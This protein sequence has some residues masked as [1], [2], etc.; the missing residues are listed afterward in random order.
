MSNR[1]LYSRV[2]SDWGLAPLFAGIVALYLISLYD[3]AVFHTLVEAMSVTVATAVFI[4]VFHTRRLLDNHYLLFVSIGFLAFVALGI[5]H[6]LGYK[7]IQLFSGFDNDL[8]T[9]AFV[10]QRFVLASSFLFAPAFLRRKLNVPM[11]FLGFGVVTVFVLASLLVWRN[12]PPM[13]VDPVG[14]TPLKKGLEFVL[15]AM[16][17][18]AAMGLARNRQ[19]FEPNVLNLAL[20]SLGCF[21]ASEVSFTL[22]ATPFGLSNLLGHLFQVAAFWFIYRAVLVTALVNPFGLLFRQLA[23]R[24]SSLSEA[25][26]QLN[27]IAAVSDAA[28]SSLEGDTLGPVVLERLVEVMAADAG[29]LFLYDGEV[30]RADSYVGIEEPGFA[31]R[32]GEG[33]AGSIA[34]HRQPDFIE[35]IQADARIKS[36]FLR[37]QGVRSI[38]G[39]PLVSGDRL[40]GVLHVDWRTVHPFSEAEMRLLVI[41]GDRVA[42]AL[43]NSQMYENEHHIAQVLQ[44]SLLALPEMVEGVCFASAY[45]SASQA[46]RVG[47]DFYDV[48]E[49]DSNRVGVLVGDVSGKGLDAAVQTSLLRNTVRA[50]AMERSKTPGEVMSM[51][52]TV[53][54]K[55]T[56]SGTFATVF[57]AII[58]GRDGR[59]A[60]CNAGHTAAVVL[61]PDGAVGQFPAQSP[62]VGAFPDSVFSSA[63]TLLERGDTLFVYTDGVIESR[64]G[65]AL[66]GE[67]RLF[68]FLSTQGGRTPAEIIEAVMSDVVAFT[69]SALSDD[70]ALLAVQTC[71][72]T[73]GTSWQQEITAGDLPLL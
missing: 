2:K 68:E 70:I 30:L 15:S 41:I 3:Y 33:F 69:E 17:I 55:A 48:F 27:A 11:A 31:L 53:F 5:P 25:N 23:E 16:F 18:G 22:Y 38:L 60:Y 57:F 65:S 14:L 43:S 9:Q 59:V 1:E 10:A 44:E 29:A 66:Y 21:A 6:T 12:F 62:L 20:V 52:N 54:E 45:Q 73:A 28:I 8:P 24:E 42:L 63:E 50:H 37:Q 61:G 7:G 47:G 49:L 71:D 19:A 4:V 51:T 34:E 26:R 72:R 36:P 64:R 13:F 35:D 40:V 67:E 58:D 46:A 56:D 39:V 32:V